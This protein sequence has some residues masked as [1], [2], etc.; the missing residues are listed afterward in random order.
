MRERQNVTGRRRKKRRVHGIAK[1]RLD[2]WS[3]LGTTRT[4]AHRNGGAET[5]AM[6]RECQDVQ[7]MTAM[8]WLAICD[9][10]RAIRS[11]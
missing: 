7:S 8:I 1:H 5:S 9:R 11:P 10:V 2:G 6:R 4:T 3:A